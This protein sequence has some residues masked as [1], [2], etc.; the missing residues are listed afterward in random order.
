MKPILLEKRFFR[1]ESSRYGGRL[2]T[3][4][5]N[6]DTNTEGQA[7]YQKMNGCC[8]KDDDVDEDVD[9]HDG[10]TRGGRAGSGGNRSSKNLKEPYAWD[11]DESY[12][13]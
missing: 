12:C 6:S 3:H 11:V 9:G 13:T 7:Y 5:Y 1:I 8:H 2:G 4:V 10:S